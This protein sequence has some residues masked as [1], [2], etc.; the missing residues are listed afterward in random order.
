[1][2]WGMNH[3]VP[4]PPQQAEKDFVKAESPGDGHS[5]WLRHSS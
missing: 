5:G 2:S 4:P 1:M 3:G